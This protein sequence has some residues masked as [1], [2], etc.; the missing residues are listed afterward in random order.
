MFRYDAP[1]R[2][3]ANT[4]EELTK[5]LAEAFKIGEDAIINLK[6]TT[7]ISS[8]GLRTLLIGL[9]TFRAKGYD[10][11]VVNVND[12]VMEIF[13]VTGLKNIILLTKEEKSKLGK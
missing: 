6:D 1:S 10:F 2:I 11:S 3:D 8:A 13:E 7:Y 4:C 5:K 12:S 9:K